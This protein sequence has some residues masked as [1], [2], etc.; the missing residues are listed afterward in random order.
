MPQTVRVPGLGDIQFPDN[1]SQDE[2]K[3]VL[4]QQVPELLKQRQNIRPDYTTGE[5]VS[6]ALT[7]GTKQLGV[8]FGDVVPAMIAKGLGFEEEAKR[9]ME[10]ARAT[11]EEIQTQY[12][13]EYQSYKDVTGPLSALGY[14]TESAL[15]Q[16]PNLATALVPGGIGAQVGRRLGLAAGERALVS[17]FAPAAGKEL[18]SAEAVRLAQEK[19]GPEAVAK[20]GLEYGGVGAGRGINTGIFL[21]SYEQNAPEVFQNIYDATGQMDVGAS[22]LAGAAAASLDSV[23]PGYLVKKFTGPNKALFVE[24]LLEKSGME[25]SL[26]RKAIATLPEAAGLEGLT[27]GAQE[28]ISIAAEKYISKNPEKFSSEEWNRI[29]ES[30]VKGAA[31]GLVFGIP[32]A[33]GS[34]MQERRAAA[35]LEPTVEEITPTAEVTPPTPTEVADVTGL[36]GGPYGGMDTTGLGADIPVSGQ[37]TDVGLPGTAQERV[38]SGYSVPTGVAGRPEGGVQEQPAPLETAPAPEVTAEVTA[39]PSNLT[40]EAESLLQ[41]VA[42]GGVP[43]MMTNNLKRIAEANGIVVTPQDT[44]NSVIEKLQAKTAEVAP[45]PVSNL[46]EEAQTILRAVREGTINED[47]L[48]ALPR[49]T[50]DNGIPVTRDKKTGMPDDK[51]MLAALQDKERAYQAA[52]TPAQEARAE[53]TPSGETKESITEHLKGEFGNN[54]LTAQKRGNLQIANTI[55]ELPE[56]V[57]SKMAPNAVGAFHKG[58]SYLIADRMDKPTARRTLLHEV[59]EHHG[60]EGMLGKDNYKQVLRQVRNLKDTDNVVKSAW[61]DVTKLYPELN[62]ADEQ[63]TREVLAKIGEVAPNSTVWRRVVGAVKNFLTKLGLYNPNKFTTADIQD[64]ILHSLRKTLKQ[65]MPTPSRETQFAKMGPTNTADPKVAAQLLQSVGDAVKNI[66]VYNS[67]IGVGARAALSKV[68]PAARKIAMS[69][70]S[71]PNKIDLY[72][73]RLPQLKQLLSAL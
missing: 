48:M 40:P 38:E 22:L 11:Q 71:L 12:A 41:S 36:Q 70:L 50:Q 2:I 51:I 73:D 23:L 28:A 25:P 67:D 13:P 21:G 39:A 6:K 4:D 24:R 8:A 29:L 20:M 66:P 56:E 33:V 45:A 30:G 32:G 52:Q 63:H 1:M 26:A 7:R 44:P 17:E 35:P 60:L 34:R 65:P 72:G 15:E 5:L 57:R 18:T 47:M 3:G 9:Q 55:D 59:G 10:E 27:E 37:P 62:P 31:A 54:I 16:V 43:A 46:T 68:S 14:V 69:F 64:L 61:L 42:D 53:I 49:V 19:L 58:T